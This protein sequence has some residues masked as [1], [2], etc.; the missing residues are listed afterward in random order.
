MDGHGDDRDEARRLDEEARR[1]E[2][3]ARGIERAAHRLE[4]EAHAIEDRAHRLEDEAHRLEAGHHHA[5]PHE[6]TV[7]INGRTRMVSGREQSYRDIARLAYPDANFDNYK[8]TITFL[9]GAHGAEGDL[10]EGEK[11]TLVEGMVFNVRRS[12]KS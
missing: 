4:D 11:V 5:H 12:D 2:N 7:K 6:F 9:H 1:L 8:Y 3:E 10:V